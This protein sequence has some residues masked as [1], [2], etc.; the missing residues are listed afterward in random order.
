MAKIS[1][2]SG[3]SIVPEGRHIFKITDV[4]YKEDF[5]KLEIKMQTENGNTHIERFSLL[6][7]NGDV[8]EGANKAFSFFA[9]TAL[10]D[11]TVTEIDP[12]ELVGCYIEC[13]VTHEIV[14][15][16]K[17]PGEMLTFAQLGEKNP[18]KGFSEEER[19]LTG[20]SNNDYSFNLD[21]VLG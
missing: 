9:K 3:F 6:R 16:T 17:K 5:G 10:D 14:E 15:S 1:L 11:F 13:E 8:N 4:T 7:A 18:A 21:D 12:S 20:E 19:V 2:I